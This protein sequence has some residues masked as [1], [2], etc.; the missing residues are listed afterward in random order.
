MTEMTLQKAAA[1][2]KRCEAHEDFISNCDYLIR[3]TVKGSFPCFER[4][5][6]A[7]LDDGVVTHKELVALFTDLRDITTTK[8]ADLDKQLEAL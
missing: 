6:H 7:A 4:W 5:L 8:L 3:N 1:L 2:Q